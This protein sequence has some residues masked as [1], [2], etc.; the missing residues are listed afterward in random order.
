ML[1]D[2][3][4]FTAILAPVTMIAGGQLAVAVGATVVVARGRPQGPP[5]PREPGAAPSPVL[6]ND[7]ELLG[8]KSAPIFSQD[9]AG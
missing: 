3:P 2:A 9:P 7:L 4:G 6:S 8:V 1:F 5:L